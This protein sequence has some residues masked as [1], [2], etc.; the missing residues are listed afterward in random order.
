MIQRVSESLPDLYEADETAWLEAMAELIRQGQVNDLDYPHLAEYLTDM[1]KRDR[2]EVKSRLTVLLTHLLKWTHQPD[3][4]TRSWRGSIVTQRQE[5]ADD[6]SGGVLRNH[7]LDVLPTV[8]ADAVERAAAETGVPPETFPKD[9]PY[10][11]AQ[12]MSPDIL[13]E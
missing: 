13:G 4:R 7:A 5:L 8:Y 6:V 11:L 12:L 3:H 9:C 2:R 1:A 10:T